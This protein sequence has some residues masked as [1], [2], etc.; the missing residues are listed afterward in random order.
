[1]LKQD[2]LLLTGGSI[3]GRQSKADPVGRDTP[4]P[5]PTSLPVCAW[6]PPTLPSAVLRPPRLT[7]T[8]YRLSPQ[9]ATMPHT[10]APRPSSGGSGR[11]QR[12]RPGGGSQELFPHGG[13]VH[14]WARDRWA[15]AAHRP[16]LSSPTEGSSRSWTGEDGGRPRPS[17]SSRTF[18]GWVIRNLSTGTSKA[19][20]DPGVSRKDFPPL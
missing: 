7:G 6:L 12:R 16:A 19:G 5:R 20:H 14:S 10:A 4:R 9:A 3:L 8:Q 2:L 11:R 18:W 17:P 13:R 1:M 15:P